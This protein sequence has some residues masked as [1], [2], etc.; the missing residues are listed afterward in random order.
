MAITSWPDDIEL[1]SAVGC[2]VCGKEQPLRELAAGPCDRHGNQLFACNRHFLS[3]RQFIVG[4]METE[5]AAEP[6]R[7]RELTGNLR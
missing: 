5:I 3:S 1:S 4:W 7:P 6:L 2:A